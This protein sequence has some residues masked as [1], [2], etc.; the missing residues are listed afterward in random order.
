MLILSL[1]ATVAASG[2]PTH[3]I[4]ADRTIAGLHFGAATPTQA[5]TRFGRPATSR[6]DTSGGCRQSWPRLGLVLLYLDLYAPRPCTTGRL[7][8]ATVTNRP[9]WRTALGLR[10]GDTTTRLRALYPR[11]TRHSGYAAWNGY[12]LVTRH[13]CKEVGGSAYPAL[14]ARVRGARVSS[15]VV[16]PGVCE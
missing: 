5:A 7:A 14:L 6:A 1:V 15:L 11:A 16:N 2:A 8:G 9:R 3:V 13:V 4:Q 10:V 12:W